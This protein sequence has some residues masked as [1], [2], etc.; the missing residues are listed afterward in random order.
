MH[1]ALHKLVYLPVRHYIS[2]AFMLWPDICVLSS[3][4][5][6][7]KGLKKLSRYIFAMFLVDYFQRNWD[8]CKSKDISFRNLGTGVSAV[9]AGFMVV[10]NK[11][12]H[13]YIHL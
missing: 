11:R 9:L 3:D 4:D 13:R 7:L 1:S 6:L 2:V 5:V 10:I 8:I 12:R